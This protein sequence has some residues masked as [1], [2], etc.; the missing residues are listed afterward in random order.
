M[1]YATKNGDR[2]NPEKTYLCQFNSGRWLPMN[3][4]QRLFFMANRMILAYCA[5]RT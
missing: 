1:G 5:F 3:N 2:M 4:K